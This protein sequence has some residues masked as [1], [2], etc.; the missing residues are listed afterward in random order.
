MTS[1]DTYKN[2]FIECASGLKNYD[3][4]NETELVNGYC[5]AYDAHDDILSNQYYAA[6][7]VK[8]WYKIYKYKETCKS[9][10]LEDEDFICWLEEAL[11]IAL[12]YRDWKDPTKSIYGDPKAVDKI[13]NRCCF[14]IRGYYYQEFNKDK[15]KINYLTDSIEG[16]LEDFGDSAEAN[17]GV[18]EEKSSWARDLVSNLI[19]KGKV[20]EAIIIDNICYQDSFKEDSK[21]YYV[22]EL[23]DSI[24]ANEENEYD[25][26]YIEPERVKVKY[27]S[28]SFNF[29]KRKLKKQLSE[30]VDPKNN[31]QL[32]NY[33]D[34]FMRTYKDVSSEDLSRAYVV[35]SSMSDKEMYNFIDK[36]LNSAK[37]E[38]KE[39]MEC[40]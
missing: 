6:L 38:L 27:T 31:S 23:D 18:E 37:S 3:K 39:L 34:Y 25:N 24:E 16:Q 14:S 8:Y 13:I 40:H 35:F 19:K 30:M 17:F 12:R 29:S 11:N 7:M 1:L 28:T 9:T 5:D 15:R 10:R 21:S 36:T 22:E 33:Y 2:S 4:L 26:D 32:K 20:E